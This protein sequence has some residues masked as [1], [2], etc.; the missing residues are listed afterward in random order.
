MLK[1]FLVGFAV[2]LFA[3][4]LGYVTFALMGL[5][6]IEPQGSGPEAELMKLQEADEMM[7]LLVL[8]VVIAAIL[9]GCI[10]VF[11]LPR[12]ATM[13]ANITYD[14]TSQA[15]VQPTHLDAGR[16]LRLQGEFEDAIEKFS[17]A[18]EEDEPDRLAWVEIAQI[19]EEDLEDIDAAIATLKEGWESHDWEPDDDVNFMFRLAE[20]HVECD[21]GRDEAIVLYKLVMEKYEE[22]EY[23]VN[24]ARG[25]LQNLG[26]VI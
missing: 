11:V 8:C 16:S 3:V 19:Q 26:V 17:E 5:G 9:G 6:D 4:L 23:H 24:R 22:N 7:K 25:S 2:I 20:L 14:Q 21:G 1:T 12:F 15:F 18:I 10:I 13:V